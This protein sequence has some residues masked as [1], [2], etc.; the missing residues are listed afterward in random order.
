MARVVTVPHRIHQKF[1]FH[2]ER[3]RHAGDEFSGT[4]SG[5]EPPTT[6]Q[7]LLSLFSTLLDDKQSKTVP[8]HTI[9]TMTALV[10]YV[11]TDDVPV[12]RPLIPKVL[13]I[14]RDL[15]LEDEDQ[16]CEALELFDE[17]VE[18]EVTI[19]VPHIKVLVEFCL[20]VAANDNLGDNIRVK[21]LSF[22]SW[23]TRLKK[24]TI[25]KHKLVGPIISVVFPIMTA[26]P[27]D[28]DEDEEDEFTDEAEVSR[29]S[30]FASQVI[31]TLALHLPPEKLL[32]PLMQ[33]IEPALQSENPYHRKAALI[34]LAVLA[35][36]CA[37]RIR[38]KY[39][40]ALLQVVCKGIQD[41]HQVVRNAALFTLGQFSEH[42]QPDVSSYHAEIL[43]LLFEYMNQVQSQPGKKSSVGV[44]KMYY[45]LEM[46]CENL[47]TDM[48]LPYLPTLMETVL[49]T[50]QTSQSVHVKELAISAIGATANAAKGHMLPYFQQIIEH[51]K[52]YL[53][54]SKLEDD[55]VL[56]IQAID[57]LGVLAR[58]IGAEHFLPLAEECIQLGLKLVQDNDDPD[59]RRCTYGLFASISIVLK[60]N[61]EPYLATITKLMVDSIM[62]AEGVVPHYKEEENSFFQL[63][64]EDDLEESNEDDE[65]GLDDDD[66]EGFSVGNAYLDEKEDSCNALGEIASNTGAAF[67]PY[68]EQCFTEVHK[69]V[70][71][72]ASDI[73]KA[74]ITCIGQF[75]CSLHRVFT[76]T[77]T[78]DQTGAL[79]KLL[80]DSVP[81]IIEI[82]NTDQDRTVVMATL[83]T[84]SEMLKVIGGSVVADEN[85]LNAL[86]TS[87]RNVLQKKTMCQGEEEE[88]DF[89]DDEQQAEYD[90]MLIECAG[91]V[92]PALAGAMG[93]Q[94]FAPYFAGFLPL[95]LPK[96]KQTCQVS[97]KSFA[98][99]VLSETIKH[100][101]LG[102]VPFV[103]HLYPI[104]VN[105]SKDEDDEVRNNSVY[106]LGVLAESGREILYD[107]YP[108]ILNILFT[109]ASKES[110]PQVVDNVCAAVCRL[111]VTNI[112][113]IPVEQVF[114]VLMQ[115]LPLKKD[116]EE[117]TTVFNC[118]AYLFNNQHP[119]VM[120]QLPQIL[121]IIGQVL[122]TEQIN[123]DTQ[124]LLIQLVKQLQQQSPEIFQ[125][126]L[127]SLSEDIVSKLSAAVAME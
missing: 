40:Q 92:V 6:S 85:H 41:S 123:A 117:N 120:Q 11:G 43:P 64:D 75:C 63:F 76:E 16:A 121:G 56:Q 119:L 13:P 104:M 82:I 8:F 103:Q 33:Y 24:K 110:K 17:L 96:T 10:E 2:P 55:M 26:V 107:K 44:T 101:G 81:S 100:M 51:L 54:N 90:A 4:H 79:N 93:G 125:N 62:S 25:I 27:D 12:F 106:G 94:R 18:C 46:F 1:K 86:T 91:D 5:G 36:G 22:I 9:K 37:D 67:L 108:E 97:D 32:Q 38:N 116:F 49:S 28:I 53:M 95:L 48:L 112:S 127:T 35:E 111:I 115:C 57:T 29:P 20:E 59:L 126:I 50:L 84:T 47:G 72:P 109:L 21:A 88:D 42:L 83:E 105:G 61:M 114:P 113:G 60:S 30:A 45:A 118:I 102:I 87:V 122:G 78:P 23:L 34:C 39:L 98:I 31:D 69:V 58:Q 14:I 3:G 77:N 74:S 65:N 71:H 70:D 66:I 15:I 7:I 124:L 73:R 89:V 19:V 99:G 80:N 68:L 52:V